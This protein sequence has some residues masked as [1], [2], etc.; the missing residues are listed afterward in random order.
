MKTTVQTSRAPAALG[1]YAQG[2]VFSQ[3]LFTSGQ[4][5]LVPEQMSFVAG[6]IKEQTRQALHNLQAVI[7]EAGAGLHTVL[8]VTCFIADMEDFP[9]FNEVYNEFFDNAL[10]ARSCVEVSRL[11]KDALIELEAIAFVP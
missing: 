8:K 3:L 6:G 11:P 5:G 9:A 4:L 7:E 2:V 1:P 10:P